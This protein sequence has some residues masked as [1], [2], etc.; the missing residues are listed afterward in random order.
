MVTSFG[1]SPTEDELLW[2]GVW[3]QTQHLRPQAF[4]HFKLA[5]VP[6]PDVDVDR[7]DPNGRASARRNLHNLVDLAFAEW[8]HVLGRINCEV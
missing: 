1:E 5:E 3:V 7:R 6:E 2:V 4:G 8:A